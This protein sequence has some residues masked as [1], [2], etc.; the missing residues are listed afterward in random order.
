MGILI[1]SSNNAYA[2]TR[3]EPIMLMMQTDGTYHITG[4]C[5]IF[6]SPTDI[7]TSGKANY[8]IMNV[9]KEQLNTSIHNIVYNHLKTVV[10]PGAVDDI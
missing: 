3:F 10:F 5:R 1:P 2:S 4:T 6:K 7:Y 8:V 9:T